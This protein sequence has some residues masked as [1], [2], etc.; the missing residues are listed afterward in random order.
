MLPA[1][2]ADHVAGVTPM[3]K[4][5]P[6]TSGGKLAFMLGALTFVPPLFDYQLMFTAWLGSMQQP[7]GLSAMVVGGALFVVGK[8]RQFRN[9]GPV[10]S[11]TDPEALGPPTPGPLGRTVEPP[12]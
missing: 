9:A 3:Q 8:L 5:D 7:V 4:Q 11:P 1:T 6:I 12:G 2:S 10:L